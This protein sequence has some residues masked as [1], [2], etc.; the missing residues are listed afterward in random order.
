V[1]SDGDERP[2]LDGQAGARPFALKA[3]GVKG[4]RHCSSSRAQ[5]SNR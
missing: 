1:E 5:V 3:Y 2:D 4:I